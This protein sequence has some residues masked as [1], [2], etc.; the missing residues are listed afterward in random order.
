MHLRPRCSEWLPL[1]TQQL[2]LRNLARIQGLNIEC[3]LIANAGGEDLESG[4][5]EQ[6]LLLYYTLHADKASEAF[7]TSEPLPQR[8]QHQK[9]AEISAGDDVWRK[10]NAQCVCVK[11]WAHY[12]PTAAQ[13]REKKTTSGPN[14]TEPTAEPAQSAQLT[15]RLA[16]VQLTP[17]KLPRP[18]ELVFSWGVYFSG[19]IPLATLSLANCRANCLIFHLNGEHFTS[20]ALISEQ[21]LH[22]QLHLQYQRYSEYDNKEQHVESDDGGINSPPVS[23][24]SS[25]MLRMSITRYT[26]LGCELTKMRYSYNL[27]TLLLLQRRQRDQLKHRRDVLAVSAEIARLSVRCI[28]RNE[29]R[30]KPRSTS[31]S[32]S[33]Y[34]SQTS[35]HYRHSM[36]RMLTELL[37]EQQEIAPLTLYS[38][39]QLTLQIEALRC[40]QRLLQTERAT[41]AE[42]N[43]RQKER[44]QMLREQREELQFK[45]HNQRLQLEQQHLEWRTQSPQRQTQ[46]KQKKCE[47][48]LQVKRRR[49][50]LA[51]ELQEIYNIKSL[52][53][54]QFSI[55]DIAFP[56][57]EHYTCE[58]RQA[59]NAQMLGNVSPLAVSAALSY[60]AHLVQMLAFIMDLPLR[61]PISYEPSRARITDNVKELTYNTRDFPLYTRSIL[62]SQQTKYAIYLLRQNVSQLCYVITERNDMRNTFGNL[63]VLFDW[64]RK[65]ND[66]VDS[67]DKW[68]VNVRHANGLTATLAGNPQLSESHSSVDMNHVPLP[69]TAN[70]A[71]D[72]LMQHLMPAGV[73]QALAIEGYASTQRICRSVGSYSDGEDD[74]RARLEQSYSNSDSNINLQV[75]RR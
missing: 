68:A 63:L 30:L 29:L 16:N 15:Q 52:G 60:V 70:V 21:G 22:A 10:S 39:Q 57:M 13:Q 62:P 55:C 61:N 14:E 56:H 1:A 24:S 71:K 49:F 74:F 35:Q 48:N 20:P 32:G 46:R 44:L 73:S 38:A 41:F 6:E 4:Q 3:S 50:T 45:L 54:Q 23:R 37:A 26:Q 5:E 34:G 25:P 33:P 64:L 8:H 59:A 72:A 36:G 9:W 19:L 75:E 47:I 69:T 51:L 27:E 17:H 28:T 58:S 11:V 42:R 40:K 12:Q 2:R 67:G 65:Q 18:P 7:Y 43:E 53:S 31:S 66:E